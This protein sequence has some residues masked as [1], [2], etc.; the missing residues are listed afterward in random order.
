MKIAGVVDTDLDL[1]SMRFS[2]HLVIVDGF[3]FG[4][5]L[6]T[7]FLRANNAILNWSNNTLVIKNT[8]VSL[9]SNSADS[10]TSEKAANSLVY[11]CTD[12]VYQHAQNAWFKAGRN[13]SL[14]Q[15][16]LSWFPQ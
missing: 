2:L 4:L 1:G 3:P 16:I 5:I 8:S 11:L 12:V 10:T 6:G 7:D 9:L 13:V 14:T 15:W